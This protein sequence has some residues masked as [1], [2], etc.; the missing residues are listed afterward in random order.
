MTIESEIGRIAT[1]LE[2]LAGVFELARGVNNL[3]TPNPRPAD[4]SV[5]PT[6]EVATPSAEKPRRGRPPKSEQTT[7]PGAA[8]PTPAESTKTATTTAM[9]AATLQDVRQ[10]LNAL[11]AKK[12]AAVA[13]GLLSN[14]GV[15]V[16]SQL[17]ESKYSEVIAAA[18]AAAA[19]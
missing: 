9:A 17:V 19:A 10:A 8:T 13:K 16:L 6:T 1:A 5:I 12:G 15:V 18:N 14:H 11:Q 2:R 3:P 4:Q 7:T